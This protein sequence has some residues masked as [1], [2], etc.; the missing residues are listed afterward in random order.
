MNKLGTNKLN[1][2]YG[3]QYEN[4]L[5]VINIEVNKI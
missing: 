5:P 1:K 4:N 2:L 3:Y